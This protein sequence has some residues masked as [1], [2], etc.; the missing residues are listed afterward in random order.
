[1]TFDVDPRQAKAPP[2]VIAWIVL[3]ILSGVSAGIAFL[4][5]GIWVL[6][7]HFAIAGLQV[8]ILFIFFMR[9]KGP[10]SLKWIFAAAGFFWLL[11]LYGLS[12]T[13]Y[14]SRTGWPTQQTHQN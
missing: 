9:L 2:F 4:K 5:F 3:L 6:I 10:P 8:A 7:A 12:A 1:M 11:F 14:A 13:D